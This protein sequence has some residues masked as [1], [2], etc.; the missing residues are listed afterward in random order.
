[1]PRPREE[2]SDI[3]RPL[4]FRD[5]LDVHA[6]AIAKQLPKVDAAPQTAVLFDGA[7]TEGLDQ[8]GRVVV[9]EDAVA[10]EGDGRPPN[11]CSIFHVLILEGLVLRTAVATLLSNGGRC[12]LLSSLN[13]LVQEEPV[14]V[15]VVA[16]LLS[17]SSHC[18]FLSCL[19]LIVIE[20]LVLVIVLVIGLATGNHGF[21][22]LTHRCASSATSSA[23]APSLGHLDR[24]RHF[25]LLQDL[26][27]VGPGVVGGDEER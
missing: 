1:M 13:V 22:T 2:R 6:I 26:R 20:R 21:A 24:S 12:G 7:T 10:K 8:A 19:S 27:G 16:T 23:A 17:N 18:G 25:R 14:L 3:G 9:V 4:V 11:S 5:K 15:I